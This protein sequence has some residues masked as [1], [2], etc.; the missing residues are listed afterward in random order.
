MTKK[1]RLSICVSKMKRKAWT[2][3]KKRSTY[4]NSDDGGTITIHDKTKKQYK[5]ISHMTFT[6]GIRSRYM[7]HL[8]R[9]FIQCKSHLIDPYNKAP[10]PVVSAD[11]IM[12]ARTLNTADNKERNG[13][14]E[15]KKSKWK[16][17]D[18]NIDSYKSCHMKTNRSRI[19][20]KAAKDTEAGAQITASGW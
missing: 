7:R 6:T 15:D 2:R 9:R 14:R 1:L 8:K 18:K 12:L 10:T 13:W 20:Q 16:Q 3:S 4:R 11:F 5:A 17:K 19:C